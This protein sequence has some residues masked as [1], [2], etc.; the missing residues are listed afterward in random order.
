MRGMH[1]ARGRFQRTV[2]VVLFFGA[3]FPTADT[4]GGGS[5]SP[6]REIGCSQ[7]LNLEEDE[8]SSEIADAYGLE[9]EV[10]NDCTLDG[11]ITTVVWWG[12]YSQWNP[13]DP[14]LTSFNLR[15]YADQGCFPGELLAEFMGMSPAIEFAGYDSLGYPSYK[16]EVTLDMP[17]QNFTFWFGAQGGDHLFPPQWG[18]GGNGGYFRSCPSMFKSA[19]YGYPDWVPVEDVIGRPWDASQEFQ[20]EPPPTAS[21]GSTWGAIRSHYR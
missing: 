20:Y 16:Y 9:S 15:F 18:R 2:A 10:I 17:I 5:G 12:G 11:T 13:G 21:R 19:Y 1:R 8:V 4:V 7:L 6:R 3:L 14:E